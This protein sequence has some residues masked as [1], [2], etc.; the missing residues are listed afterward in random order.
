[1]ESG[2]YAVKRERVQEGIARGQL[3][4]ITK[5]AK[6]KIKGKEKGGLTTYPARLPPS[7]QCIRR[8]RI[9]HTPTSTHFTP[10][11]NSGHLPPRS[12]PVLAI[13]GISVSHLRPLYSPYPPSWSLTAFRYRHPTNL[14]VTY[15]DPP[16]GRVP[17]A[18]ICPRVITVFLEG[19]LLLLAP[20]ATSFSCCPLL[21][22]YFAHLLF[23][24]F[25]TST[26]ILSFSP[27][28]FECVGP[29]PANA[30]TLSCT[31]INP[32]S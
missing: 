28:L 12:H 6:K 30:R 22:R 4:T 26:Y 11:T 2:L 24:L 18:L 9:F 10:K 32:L 29:C 14:S 21:K 19:S 16:S 8:W 31:S 25:R 13:L 17:Y 7:N 5:E 23:I 27:H 20:A 15:D 3:E 1:M